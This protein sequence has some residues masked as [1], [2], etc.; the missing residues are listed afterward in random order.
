MLGQQVRSLLISRDLHVQIFMRFQVRF[1]NTHKSICV[2][3]FLA[4]EHGELGTWV[5]TAHASFV[6]VHFVAVFSASDLEYFP[7]FPLSPYFPLFPPIFP[8]IFPFF[9]P[10]FSFFPLFPFFL[11]SPF[12]PLFPTI[13][14]FSLFPL[15]PLSPYFPFFFLEYFPR[16]FPWTRVTEALGVRLVISA[17]SEVGACAH[18]PSALTAWPHAS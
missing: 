4:H 1:W 16:P 18:K 7:L 17:G 5:H 6:L 11:F 8:P 2:G 13:S 3:Q 9:F 15:F 12:F 14:P 10:F